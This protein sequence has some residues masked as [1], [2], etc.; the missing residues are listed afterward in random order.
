MN[1]FDY[2]MLNTYQVCQRRFYYRHVRHLVTSRR[3]TP[4]EFGS[5]IHAAL[6]TWYKEGDEAKALGDFRRVWEEK[7]GD[8]TDDVKRTGELGIKIIRGYCKKYAQEPFETVDIEIPFQIQIGEYNYIGRMDKVIKWDG[9]TGP[10]DHK[11][12]SQLGY[13]TFDQYNPNMQ[14]DGYMYACRQLYDENCYWAVPDLLCT[15]KTKA[16]TPD[17][18]QRKKETRTD[19]QIEAFPNIFTV[20][21]K[22]VSRSM[23]LDQFIPCYSSCTYYGSCPYRQICM[24]SKEIQERVINTFY[25]EDKWDPRNDI[26]ESKVK[27]ITVGGSNEKEGS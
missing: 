10:L 26:D 14:L 21:A 1:E 27:K 2:S 11:T 19:D 5:A 12:S 13:H 4:L 16:G 25:T 17:G 15:A 18:F 20:L 24:E 8:S 7:G 23:E 3:Q 6:D 9:I 22:E